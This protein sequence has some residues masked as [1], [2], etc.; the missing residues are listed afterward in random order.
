MRNLLKVLVVG[1]NLA[2]VTIATRSNKVKR[3]AVFM[4]GRFLFECGLKGL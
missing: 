1:T 3:A 2:S 4:V